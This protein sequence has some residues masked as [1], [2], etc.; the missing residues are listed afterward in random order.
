MALPRPDSV[1]DDQRLFV[2]APFEHENDLQH[3]DTRTRLVTIEHKRHPPKSGP[4]VSWKPEPQEVYGTLSI[5]VSD[6]LGV[7]Q[8]DDYLEPVRLGCLR[9]AALE[10]YDVMADQAEKEYATQLKTQRA[11]NAHPDSNHRTPIDSFF[12]RRQHLVAFPMHTPIQ[13]QSQTF[14]QED[15][16]GDLSFARRV[17]DES[18]GN[19]VK[20]RTLGPFGVPFMGDMQDLDEMD[21]E[22]EAREWR[23]QNMEPVVYEE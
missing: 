21:R 11:L 14:I 16:G 13:L 4:S 12:Y 1:L 2:K 8:D 6:E 10:A 15:Y 9:T 7:S 18:L 5:T 17:L 23:A 3:G 19:L 22:E 20:G